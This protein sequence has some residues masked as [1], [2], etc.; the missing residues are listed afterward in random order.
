[1][2]SNMPT[3]RFL[4]ETTKQV[5]SGKIHGDWYPEILVKVVT[6]VGVPVEVALAYIGMN[7]REN[8][9]HM[10]C[11]CEAVWIRLENYGQTIV[12]NSG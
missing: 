5:S 11:N 2:V 12:C 4:G 1:M 6:Y 7:S 3:L 8:M 10:E 9:V